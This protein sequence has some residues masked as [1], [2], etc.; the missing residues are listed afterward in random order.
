MG[1]K[2]KP[3]RQ[4]FQSLLRS[5]KKQGVSD[6]V[7]CPGGRN[8]ALW[9]AFLKSS[10]FKTYR[11][12]D[13]RSAAFFA[14]GRSFF[15]KPVVVLCTSGSALANFYP[16][17]T[18]AYYQKDSKLIVLSADRPFSYRGTGAPQTMDQ[19]NFYGRFARQFFDLE[20]DQEIEILDYPCHINVALEDPFPM[21]N[22][23]FDSHKALVIVS[24]LNPKEREELKKSLHAYEGPMV[25]ESLSNLSRRDF[26]KAYIIKNA[27]LVLNKLGPKAFDVVYR[28]G[29]VPVLK[30]WRALEGVE[31][32]YC[33]DFSDWSGGLGV[34]PLSLNQM[35]ES[36]LSFEPSNFENLKELDLDLEDRKQRALESFSSSEISQ[37][38]QIIRSLPDEAQ[39]FLSNSLP[40]RESEYFKSKDHIYIGQRGLNGI[41][42]SL[43]LALGRLNPKVENWILLGDLSFL[44]NQN[45]LQVLS[46]LSDEVFIRIVVV[47]NAGGQ[48][49]SR[50][51]LGEQVE[52]FVNAQS[53]DFSFIAKAWGLAYAQYGGQDLSLLPNKSLIEVKVDNEQSDAFWDSLKNA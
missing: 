14:L 33:Q 35:S 24:E 29:G 1:Y 19:N 25:L 12:F 44:Y 23:S 45:D 8:A 31:S 38:Y 30:F 9:A 41:D 10:S 34:K 39:V 26:P 5:L 37:I 52:E 48:I 22:Q 32:F 15:G 11:F 46:Q 18:E 3:M 28:F 50:L 13:E 2:L 20:K 36:I 16:A 53:V 43:A 49:F 40:I 51:A 6:V 21:Q 47:N 27:D 17:V 7:C 4:D 42:G